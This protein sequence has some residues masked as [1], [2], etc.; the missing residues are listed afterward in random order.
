MRSLIVAVTTLAVLGSSKIAVQEQAPGSAAQPPPIALRAAR[1]IDVRTGELISNAVLLID[2]GRF[3]A[4]GSGLAIPR[5]AQVIDLG[6]ATLLPGLIEG[7]AHLMA[8]LGAGEPYHAQ[9]VMRSQAARA[10]EGAASARETLE[11]GFTTVRDA[12]SE[13]A[14]YADV[15]LRDAINSGLVQ[16][17]RLFVAGRAIAAVGQ[18]FPFGISPDLEGRLTGA[19]MISGADEARR[20]VRE[21]IGYGADFIKIY[22]DW[23]YP[24]LTVD[25]M[26]VIVEESHKLHRQVAA[27]ATTPEGIRNAVTAGVDAI[28]HGFQPDR[29]TL[30]RMKE[31]GTFLVLTVGAM[32]P[33]L[34]EAKSE[35][36]R[37][38]LE[39]RTAPIRQ[40]IATAREVGVKI[41]G[42][43]DAGR[44]DLQGKNARQLVVL[45]RLGMTPLEALRT[46]TVDGAELL[47]WADRVGT[48]EPGRFADVIAVDGNPLVDIGVL[49]H[50][51]FVMKGGAV[52][53][54]ASATGDSTPH[55]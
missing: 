38:S 11:A 7:H 20:A 30:Q 22:A 45:V 3:S 29:E 5:G 44:A 41:A 6:N 43:L 2:A 8:R 25:E 1:M 54:S 42:G 33:A 13:G 19:Q 10:L 14:G 12:G 34:E 17:P 52:V 32:Y 55:R 40:T 21:Q 31:K 48:L 16:G 50:V 26:R 39:K 15:A 46:Q 27:H 24:T 53:K 28:E 18:Y 4:V 23:Q 37:A 35:S 47:G 51:R 49:E 9:L 36:Q